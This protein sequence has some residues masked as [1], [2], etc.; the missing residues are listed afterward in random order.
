[1]IVVKPH[2]K[3]VNVVCFSPDG[4][5]LASA[6]DDGYM[7]MWDP[8]EL[9]SGLPLWEADAENV[10][11]EPD[12][13]DEDDFFEFG[14]GSAGVSHAQFTPDGKLLITSGWEMHVRAW[15]A[16]NGKAKWNVVKPQ[17]WGGVGT[18]TVARDGKH[19]AFAGGQMGTDERVYITDVKKGAPVRS[20]RGH[21]NACGALASGPDGFVSGGADKHVR[22]WKWAGGP[23][24]HDLALRGVVRGLM[25]DR[26]GTRLAASGGAVVTVWDMQPPA[27]KGARRKPGKARYFRGHTDQVQSIDFAPDGVTLA[28]AAHDGTVRVWDAASGKELRAFAPGVGPLHHVAFAPDG[29]TLAFGSEAGHV[30]LLD[31]GD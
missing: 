23:C 19:F 7:K 31:L 12:F 4:A 29:L 17:G 21:A 6:S 13:D 18:V 30:G 9:Y 1:V 5:R 15:D 2:E 28:S 11:D 3:C 27:R 26:E 16:R 25:F 8:A 20:V 24:Y 22:F 14:L 10:E